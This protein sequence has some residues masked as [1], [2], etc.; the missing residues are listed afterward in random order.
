MGRKAHYGQALD[1]LRRYA[2]SS[3]VKWCTASLVLRS[4]PG[5]DGWFAS[6]N[7][8]SASAEVGDD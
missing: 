3:P 7:R 6:M 2:R 5:C 8:T 4:E 1:E